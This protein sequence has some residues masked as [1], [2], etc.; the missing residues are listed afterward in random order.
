MLENVECFKSLPAQDIANLDALAQL[1]T[2]PKNRVIVNKGDEANALY[3]VL[4]GE[5]ALHRETGGEAVRALARLRRGSFFGET[6]LIEGSQRREAARATWSSVV[7]RI[8]RE[9][10]VTF[11]DN[12]PLIALKLEMAD[13]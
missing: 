8:G 11:L 13:R 5:V 10:L 1:R 6:D 3:V 2:Y 9:D 7:L 12:H 4:E